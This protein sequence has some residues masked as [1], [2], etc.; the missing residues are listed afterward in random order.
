M[1]TTT[2]WT[3]TLG[4]PHPLWTVSAV[5]VA[6]ALL[7][8]LAFVE[9]RR[10]RPRRRVGLVL[11]RVATLLLAALVV[12]QPTWTR[13]RLEHLS[14]R[15]AV[16]LDASRSMT[17]DGP[18]GRERRAQAR[19]LA[20]RWAGEAT[21]TAVSVYTVGDRLEPTTLALQTRCSPN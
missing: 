18:G 7:L 21:P 4:A 10:L 19:K 3:F 13:E 16:L 15:V 14:G 6:A 1:Q 8:A 5:V 17:I 2:D 11:L 9:G 20:Q 12:L